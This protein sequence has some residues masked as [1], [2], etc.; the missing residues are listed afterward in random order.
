MYLG[1]F[2]EN[3]YKLV[4]FL[5]KNMHKLI[6]FEESLKKKV[7]KLSDE[8]TGMIRRKTTMINNLQSKVQKLMI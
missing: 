7:T 6:A 4:D 1:L 8:N 3:T 5:K 2:S